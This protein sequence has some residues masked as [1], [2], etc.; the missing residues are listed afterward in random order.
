MLCGFL[1][2]TPRPPM[3]WFSATGKGNIT[4]SV[5]RI[6]LHDAFVDTA[7]SGYNKQSRNPKQPGFLQNAL[8]SV[9]LDLQPGHRCLGAPGPT[10]GST[11]SCMPTLGLIRRYFLCIPAELYLLG[12]DRL[13]VVLRV[14]RLRPL[15]EALMPSRQR[16]PRAHPLARKSQAAA[17]FGQKNRS[18]KIGRYQRSLDAGVGRL[19]LGILMLL[20]Q[21][22]FPDESVT[23]LAELR[24]RFRVVGEQVEVIILVAAQLYHTAVDMA[25]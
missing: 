10:V 4:S 25:I 21:I 2:T 24:Q 20:Q 9:R 3:S 8:S 18:S 17:R 22:D 7:P 23:E 5:I 14:K 6:L 15:W 16:R 1:A 12:T 19:V 11:A 13:L